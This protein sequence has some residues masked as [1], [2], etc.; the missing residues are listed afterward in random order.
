MEKNFEDIKK[1][2]EKLEDKDLWYYYSN[3]NY[4]TSK[5][6]LPLIDSPKELNALA[7]SIDRAVEKSDDEYLHNSIVRYL[8]K[9]TGIVSE[10]LT[11]IPPEDI[12]KSYKKIFAAGLMG[13]YNL[14]KKD[15]NIHALL[16]K[17]NTRFVEEKF[18][19][20]GRL[21]ETFEYDNIHAMISLLD[22]HQFIGKIVNH[23]SK[24]TTF[25]P[26]FLY[27]V[28]SDNNTND[29]ETLSLTYDVTFKPDDLKK[30]LFEYAKSADYGFHVAFVDKQNEL[31]DGMTTRFVKKNIDRL[32]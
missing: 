27:V 15:V 32:N 28:A 31:P 23:K 25:M 9:T 4:D 16:P 18:F 11:D 21:W 30:H 6:I 3:G 2:L 22:T 5:M 13:D 1:R 26:Q 20:I 12:I 8:R 17:D 10:R 14:L 7:I 24:K 29:L 19:S